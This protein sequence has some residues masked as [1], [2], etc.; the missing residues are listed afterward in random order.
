ME[1][2][3][4]YWIPSIAPSCFEFINSDRYGDWQGSL[5]AGALKFKYL[6]RIVL[7]KNKVV[8]REKIAEDLGRP[9]DVKESKDGYIHVSIENKGIY[10]IV[11]KS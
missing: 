7:D 4:Y 3:L 1:Q 10:K 8:Y 6:E 9:R 11:P 5:L 2:P